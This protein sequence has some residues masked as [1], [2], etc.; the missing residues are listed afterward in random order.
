LLRAGS[1]PH[2]SSP[3]LSTKAHLWLS[4][5]SSVTGV[6]LL[7]LAIFPISPVTLVLV[8][9][10]SSNYSSC[11]LVSLSA[12]LLESWP[13]RPPGLFVVNFCE[14]LLIPFQS[15]LNQAMVKELLP[16][17]PPHLGTSHKSETTSQP[18]PSQCPMISQSFSHAM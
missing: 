7:L 4:T 18:T 16:S 13:R 15:G 10:S 17:S 9:D 12:L 14:I 11:R 5:M 6:G 2:G 3:S 8:K 1:I